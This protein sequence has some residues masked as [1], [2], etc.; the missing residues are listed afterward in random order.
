MCQI[1]ICTIF[2][3]WDWDIN[4]ESCGEAEDL[5]NLAVNYGYRAYSFPCVNKLCFFPWTKK[6]PER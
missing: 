6:A 4:T 5:S 3:I 2:L 1:F